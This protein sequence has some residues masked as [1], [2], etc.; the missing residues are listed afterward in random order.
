M[1]ILKYAL[2]GSTLKQNFLFTLPSGG[3]YVTNKQCR[4]AIQIFQ[5]SHSYLKGSWKSS[6]NVDFPV[7]HHSLLRRFNNHKSFFFI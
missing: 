5:R 6:L 2:Q 7:S 4:R 3:C 1:V